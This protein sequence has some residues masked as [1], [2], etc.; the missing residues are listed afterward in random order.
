MK[1][2]LFGTSALVGGMVGGVAALFAAPWVVSLFAEAPPWAL[3]AAIV[4]LVGIGV[5]AGLLVPPAK[6]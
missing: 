3:P 1:E 2:R 6:R 5:V 4:L